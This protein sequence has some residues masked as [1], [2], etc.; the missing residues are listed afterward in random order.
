MTPVEKSL[1]KYGFK[2]QF[3]FSHYRYHVPTFGGT[4]D[5]FLQKGADGGYLLD[6]AYVVYTTNIGYSEVYTGGVKDTINRVHQFMTGVVL[7]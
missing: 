2:R 6:F 3:N 4:I 7:I 5:V 1:I